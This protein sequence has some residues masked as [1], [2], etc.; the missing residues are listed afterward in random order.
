MGPVE[1]SE[2]EVSSWRATEEERWCGAKRP[3][4]LQ[5][6]VG[7]GSQGMPMNAEKWT[8]RATAAPDRP[9]TSK[10]ELS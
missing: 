9:R 7:T 10:L 5:D 2:C 1:E 3:G 6:K 4:C 8:G